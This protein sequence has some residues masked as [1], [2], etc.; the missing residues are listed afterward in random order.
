MEETFEE[1]LHRDLNISF[2][3]RQ[4]GKS[5]SRTFVGD[6]P[7]KTVKVGN[8]AVNV[9]YRIIGGE[10]NDSKDRAFDETGLRVYDE[11]TG[12]LLAKSVKL[13]KW[14]GNKEA[15]QNICG[16]RAAI[17]IEGSIESYKKFGVVPA[18]NGITY[19]YYYKDPD[20]AE[21]TDVLQTIYNQA[22]KAGPSTSEGVITIGNRT[23]QTT[24]MKINEPYIE[25]GQGSF[26][27]KKKYT[28]MEMAAIINEVITL[29]K[30]CE[31]RAIKVK[32]ADNE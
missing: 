32:I 18:K 30:K 23:F 22:S 4:L 2:N 19:A 15:Q 5:R 29:R 9:K 21:L 1:P 27:I 16:L 3:G 6:E 24:T 12:R 17:Y 26:L 8:F 31:K 20:F 10:S 13:W 28:A 7:V 14:Y 25:V 11:K